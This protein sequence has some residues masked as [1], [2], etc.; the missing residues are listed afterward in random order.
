MIKVVIIIILKHD[1]GV[2]RGK[3]HVLGRKGQHGLTLVSVW[4]KTVIIIVLKSDSRIDLMQGSGHWLGGS[5]QLTIK[6]I[7]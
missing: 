1:L 7:V 4:I 2:D 5:T 6:K 3:T